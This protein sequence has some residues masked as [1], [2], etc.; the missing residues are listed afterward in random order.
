[1]VPLKD[2]ELCD[3]I[4]SFYYSLVLTRTRQRASA[5]RLH[6]TVLEPGT[7]RLQGGSK[8]FVILDSGQSNMV[9]VGTVLFQ[10]ITVFRLT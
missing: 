4:R 1:M 3:G 7:F 8:A 6:T 9:K 2:L 5:R 10:A